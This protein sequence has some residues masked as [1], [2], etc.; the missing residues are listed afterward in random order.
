MYL[1]RGGTNCDFN[2]MITISETKDYKLVSQLSEEVFHLH[3]KLHPEIWKPYNQAAIEK[4]L[5]KIFSDPNCKSYLAKQN[6]TNI[7]FAIFIIKEVKENSFQV[8]MK[9]IYIDQIAVLSQYRRT[10][11][12]KLLM[13]QAEK[14]AKENS[15]N[16]IA[17]D[18]WTSNVIA[19]AYF[20]KNGYN[21]YEEKLFKVI[22]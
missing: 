12:G 14:F 7:G 22:D 5:E 9:T 20:K 8:N 10:G 11:A 16:R 18:H 21:P 17:L 13:E 2:N 1:L 3:A 6:E 4:A 15:I 19:A